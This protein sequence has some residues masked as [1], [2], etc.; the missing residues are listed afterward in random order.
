M[1]P[2]QIPIRATTQEHLPIEDIQDDLVILKDGSCAMILSV[3]SLNF[4]LLSEREQEA[5]IYAY[6]ALL[7]SLTFSIQILLRS[8]RK[9]ISSYLGLLEK[10]EAKKV[11]SP[12][13]VGL[14]N[15]YRKF[16][17][18]MVKKNNVLDKKFYVV[19]PFSSLE[20]GVAPTLTSLFKKATSLPYEKNYII[21]KAKIVLIPKR[22]HLIKLFAR[23]S[24]VSKQLTS[25]EL[26]KLFYGIYNPEMIAAERE[27]Q[28]KAQNES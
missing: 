11:S 5:I 20:L 9:D 24:L 14:I 18:E 22:D 13:L 21:A 3:S 23:L 26:I 19:I 28:K 25:K 7:N 2:A 16:V 1:D 12:L 4:D 27:A 8:E 17:A 6:G 10:Q 15:S